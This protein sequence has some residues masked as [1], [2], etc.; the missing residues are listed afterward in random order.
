MVKSITQRL[1]REMSETTAAGT[2]KKTKKK[3]VIKTAA[4]E[5]SSTEE[6]FELPILY[7]EDANGR[8]RQWEVYAIGNKIYTKYG[9]QGMKLRTTPG[10][11]AKGKNA[12]RS[13]ATTATEQA[14]KEA[15]SKW[16]KK[17]DNEGFAEDIDQQ[18]KDEEEGVSRH[19]Y[20]PMLA[21][22]YKKV[23][24]KIWPMLMQPKLDGVRCLCYIDR[25]DEI[26]K[27]SRQDK[28]FD[29][30]DHFDK[31]LRVLL[32]VLP[33]G[34]V[35]DGELYADGV[36]RQQ[37]L[38][39]VKRTK[40]PHPDVKKVKY[41]IYDCFFPD[42]EEVVFGDRYDRLMRAFILVQKEMLQRIPDFTKRVPKEIED[43]IALF[44]LGPFETLVLLETDCARNE[45]EVKE[46]FA[47][48]IAEGREGAIIRNP[49]GVYEHKRSKNLLKYKTFFDKEFTVI[50]A[51]EGKGQS[52]GLVIWK[53][54]DPES[55]IEFDVVPK[56]SFESRARRWEDYQRNP[57]KYIG[58]LYEVKYL[59]LTDDQIPNP[60]V[61]IGFRDPSL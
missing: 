2:E 52:K 31:D 55:G 13:N 4:E 32:S 29:L 26:V 6:K 11:E 51:F 38:S 34:T 25:N 53:V 43:V 49:E 19:F 16:N 45:D 41:F 28:T 40:T 42:D 15:T 22:D 57:Q 44:A 47:R 5:P 30:V 39:R 27:Q 58:R 50:G 33:K 7:K 12:G 21:E 10:K 56:G 46:N 23:K 37:I 36:S 20:K 14:K 17:K 18:K 60:A 59:A 3:I 1:F 24:N 54:K 61:G 35:L 9:I 8:V 48:Y